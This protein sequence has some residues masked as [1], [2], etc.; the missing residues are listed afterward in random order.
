MS[1]DPPGESGASTKGDLTSRGKGLVQSLSDGVRA[2]VILDEKL[3]GIGRENERSRNEIA[4][5]QEAVFR[6][7][8]KVEEMERRLADRFAEL[9]KRLAEIDKRI[10]LKV[11]LAVGNAMQKSRPTKPA[12]TK[13]SKRKSPVQTTP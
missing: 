9:D 8:G 10:D 12:S 4:R 3:A 1:T 6:L 11:E 2:L 13:P 7:I 5:L